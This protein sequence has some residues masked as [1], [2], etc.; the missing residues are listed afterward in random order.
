Y[1]P[2]LYVER[3]FSSHR[4]ASA[5]PND[6]HNLLQRELKSEVSSTRFS[7]GSRSLT[8]RSLDPPEKNAAGHSPPYRPSP[9][10][11][12]HPPTSSRPSRVSW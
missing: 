10:V 9:H 5:T 2:G 1:M 6:P 8:P 7:S 11:D 12:A 3:N 4:T